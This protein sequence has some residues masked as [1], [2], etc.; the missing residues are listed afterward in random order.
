MFSRRIALAMLG[1]VLILS[2][3]VLPVSAARP[4]RPAP[5]AERPPTIS[6]R[7]LTPAELAA[8][9][10]KV[11]AALAYLASPA[12]LRFGRVT[13]DCAAPEGT[14]PDAATSGS[15][16]LGAIGDPATN[17]DCDV[18][19]DFL[20][21]SARDQSRGHYCGPA[22]GQVIANYTWAMPL[23]ANKYGLRKIAAWMQTDE[24][25][26]TSAFTMEDGLELATEGAPRRPSNWDWVVTYLKDRDGDGT[27]GDQLHDYVRSNISGSRMALAIPVLPH[28]R[29]GRFHLTSWPNPVNSPGH[30]IAA[31]GWKGLYDGTTFSRLY[32]TDSSEDEG[33]ATGR[34]W[35]PMKH[36]AGMIMDHSERFVW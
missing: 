1:A 7:P 27:V 29:D 6:E 14:P 23:D 4:T 19:S 34:F 15:A 35:D 8:S 32:Y 12:A 11:A 16:D 5:G 22:V 36:I 28:E 17:A 25:G 9:D 31:Y 21:V 3:G 33:G 24:N 30:W 13:L 2:A 10:R 26:G 18:P 20:G